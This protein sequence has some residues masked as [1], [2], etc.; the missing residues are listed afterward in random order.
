MVLRIA[1]RPSRAD[2]DKKRSIRRNLRIDIH[3]C[4]IAEGERLRPLISAILVGGRV[5]PIAALLPMAVRWMVPS[6]A[7]LGFQ[8]D[9]PATLTAAGSRFGSLHP[10]PTEIDAPE[11]RRN[12]RNR[13]SR[14]RTCRIRQ[15]ESLAV[16]T[17]RQ[18]KS[19]QATS[20]ETS[21]APRPRTVQRPGATND[22]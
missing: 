13:L 4:A 2:E 19:D 20:P 18:C 16:S 8:I 6:A 7:M 12:T 15:L 1:G 21:P 14:L 9:W 11:I 5:K 10:A 3:R 17:E 22:R